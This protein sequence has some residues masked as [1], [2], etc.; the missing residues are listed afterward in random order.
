VKIH[1][2]QSIPNPDDRKMD[3]VPWLKFSGIPEEKLNE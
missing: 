1:F 2:L 3:E